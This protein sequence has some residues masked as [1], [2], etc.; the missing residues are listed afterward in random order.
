L[1]KGDKRGP[2]FARWNRPAPTTADPRHYTKEEGRR[3]RIE[4]GIKRKEKQEN[5]A[6]IESGLVDAI[7]F[8]CVSDAM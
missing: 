8:E 7:P 6:T 4:E 3:R 1:E 5:E 2:I